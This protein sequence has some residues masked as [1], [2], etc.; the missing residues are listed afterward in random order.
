M[1]T[2]TPE[3][4]FSAFALTSRLS[5]ASGRYLARR[6][7]LVESFPASY[8]ASLVERAEALLVRMAECEDSGASADLTD[9]TLWTDLVAFA[10]E[11]EATR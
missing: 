4:R 8:P 2:V 5:D 10:A 11:M 9:R 1:T 7:S 3:I 6:P